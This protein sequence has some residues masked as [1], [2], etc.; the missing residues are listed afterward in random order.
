MRNMHK[1]LVQVS[2]K[3]KLGLD[4]VFCFFS[5]FI[6]T[7][8]PSTEPMLITEEGFSVDALADSKSKQLYGMG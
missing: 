1:F 4:I 5:V 3:M 7:L 8:I 2:I 6:L